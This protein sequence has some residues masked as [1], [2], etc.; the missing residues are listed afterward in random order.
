LTLTLDANVNIVLN[1]VQGRAKRGPDTM[2][3]ANACFTFAS[4]SCVNARFMFA[5]R[6]APTLASRSTLN[7]SYKRST[8]NALCQRL[9]L[10]A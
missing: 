5:S 3:D 4:R 2:L 9:T 1:I 10:N 6:S 8:L 7:A